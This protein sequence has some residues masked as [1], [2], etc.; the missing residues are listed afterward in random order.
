MPW[1]P[2]GGLPSLSLTIKA[3]GS[4]LGED[5]E[6]NI[7]KPQEFLGV[8]VVLVFQCSSYQQHLS[9]SRRSIKISTKTNHQHPHSNRAF[10]DSE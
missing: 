6:Y 4:T 10:W 8:S 7:N 5:A 3:A 9:N 1:D 2:L